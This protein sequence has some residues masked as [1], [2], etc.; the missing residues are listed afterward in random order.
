MDSIVVYCRVEVSKVVVEHD[1][2]TLY[3]GDDAAFTIT[4]PSYP[5]AG[6]A[7]DVA[8]WVTTHRGS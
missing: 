4:R 6:L 2:V 3:E 7:V 8:A 5:G 1:K